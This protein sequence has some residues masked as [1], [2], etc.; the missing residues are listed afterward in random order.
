MSESTKKNTLFME[1]LRRIQNNSD[2]L[3]W[4]ITAKHL[5]D[6]ARTMQ[7]S[8][9]SKSERYD[10]IYGAIS[11]HREMVR[12]VNNGVRNSLFRDKKEIMNAKREKQIW[13]NTWYLKGN[14]IGT[15]SCPTT[16][17]GKL[18]KSL[19]KAINSER[20]DSD[21]KILIIEDGG[22]PIHTGIKINDPCRPPGC[23]YGDT[24]CIVD[25]K[26]HCDL[27]SRIYKI[28]C[29]QCNLII[30]NSSDAEK[31][32]P[33][34][35]GLTRSSIHARMLDHLKGQKSKSMGNPLYR[36]DLQVHDGITQQYVCTPVVSEKKIVRLHVNEAL[37]I[38]KQNRE[39]SL[40]DK[41]ECGRGG[42]V[43]ITATRVTN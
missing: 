14:T 43:R 20:N 7:I 6:F 24:N 15:M 17:G 1:S 22:R 35:I 2:S 3:P 9:Y 4:E 36:H 29:I 27:T 23:I 10:A 28:T 33:N 11:R 18:K 42:I 19:N 12:E 37:H 41:M 40:N 38:E 39:A 25:Q 21:G 34:Y 32:S 5:T 13:S 16:P 26:Y 8:G 31:E 30:V